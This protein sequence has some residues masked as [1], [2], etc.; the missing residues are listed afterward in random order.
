[1]P[2]TWLFFKEHL[3]NGEAFFGMHMEADHVLFPPLLVF[4]E[5]G[6]NTF[7]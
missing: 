2:A 6:E 4:I 3:F 1:M 7:T 5:L